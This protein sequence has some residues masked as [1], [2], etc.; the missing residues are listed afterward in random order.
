MHNRFSLP[1]GTRSVGYLTK[2]L[3]PTFNEAQFEEQFLQW[4]YNINRYEKDNGT[5]LP[6]G[7]KIAILLNKTKGALQQHL[8]LRAG[9]ITNYNEIRVVILDYY[10][11]I[12]AF[13]RASSAVGTNYNGGTAPMDVDNIWRKEETTKAKEKEKAA[14][15]EARA[16]ASTGVKDTTKDSTKAAKETTTKEDTTRGKE[17][18]TQDPKDMDQAKAAK[19]KE[20][21]HIKRKRKQQ[22]H[23]MPSMWQAWPLGTRLQ[24]ASMA[25]RR[26]RRTTSTRARTS[27]S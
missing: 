26:R 6:D 5:A 20:L 11:T 12:S 17:K 4:E 27:R 22:L 10:K 1:V 13:S 25:H 21:Q 9:Q 7:V 8:Q 14:T 24:S 15:K 18:A 16:K 23:N 19:A 2:L 3:E